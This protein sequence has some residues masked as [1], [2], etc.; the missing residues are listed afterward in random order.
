VA[1]LQAGHVDIGSTEKRQYDTFGERR[2][3]E[4][5]SGNLRQWQIDFDDQAPVHSVHR[6]DVALVHPHRTFGDR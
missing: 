4:R 3:V 2:R 1:S 5:G 6:A